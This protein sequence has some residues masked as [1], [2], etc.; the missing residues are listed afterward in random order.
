MTSNT[1]PALKAAMLACL[2]TALFS[3]A[4]CARSVP[5]ASDIASL[6]ESLEVAGFAVQAPSQL[7]PVDAGLFEA[8]G[9]LV[10]ASKEKL[11]AFEFSDAATAGEAALRV[12]PDGSGIGHKYVN[13]SAVPHYFRSGRLIVIYDGTQKPVLNALA[14][15]M[16]PV[17]AGGGPEQGLAGRSTETR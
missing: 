6:T 12:S 13:W 17:F 8:E 7:G 10:V 9:A 1:A 11:L 15:A 2:I 4:A 14:A 16:G 5:A 3:L